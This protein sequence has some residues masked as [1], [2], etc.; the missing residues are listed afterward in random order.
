MDGAW[1]GEWVDGSLSII[2]TYIL[3]LLEAERRMLGGKTVLG[4][5]F[6]GGEGGVGWCGYT[7]PLQIPLQLPMVAPRVLPLSG[8]TVHGPVGGNCPPLSSG[9]DEQWLC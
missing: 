5:V 1:V 2:I 9:D 7:E 6:L 8:L 3:H 4:V